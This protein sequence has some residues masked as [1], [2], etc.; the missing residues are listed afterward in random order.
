MI[1][2]QPQI[3]LLTNSLRN[4]F[5]NYLKE[6]L[7]QCQSFSLSVAFISDSGL[8]LIIDELKRLEKKGIKGRLLTTNYEYKTTPKALEMLAELSNIEVKVFDALNSSRKFH[9]KGYI[10]EMND[11]FEIVVGSSNLTQYALKSNHEWNLKYASKTD[12]DLNNNL[13]LEFDNLFN[14]EKSLPLTKDFILK[15]K[16]DYYNRKLTDR[17]EKTLLKFFAEYL[18]KYPDNEFINEMIDNNVIDKTTLLDDISTLSKEEIKPNEMQEMALEGLNSIRQSGGDKALVI[19]ATGTGKTYLSAFDALQIM[20]KRL[21]FV[22]HRSKILMDALRTFKTILP[23]ISMGQYTGQTKELDNDFIFASMQTVSKKDNLMKFNRDHF[24]YIIIDEA[25]RTAADSYQ[26]VINHFKPK[27][28]LGMTAIPER[29]DSKS[30]YELYDNQIGVEIRLREALAKELVVPFHY[31]GIRDATTDLS[32]IN[33][34]TEIDKL[35]EKLNIKAR[36]DLVIENIE[37]YKHSGEKT[38]ALGYCVNVKHAQYMAD[39]FNKRGY[40]SVALTGESSE[41]LREMYIHRLED[42]NDVLSYIFTVEIFNEGIDIPSVNLVLMLRPTSSAIIFT[43]QL[44]RGLRKYK[45]KEYLTVLDF[46]GNHNKNFLLPIALAGDKAYDKDDL[47]VSTANDFFDIPGDTFIRIDPI[48]KERILKQLEVI[49]FNEMGYLKESYQDKKKNLGRIPR[50]T[51]FAFDEF[52]PVRFIKKKRSYIGFVASLEKDNNTI[53]QM[54]H[55]SNFSKIIAY[56]DNQLPIKR[57]YEYAIL[58]ELMINKSL[59]LDE[60]F[61]HMKKYVNRPNN[62][63]YRHAVQNLYF[64]FSSKTDKNKYLKL[65]SLDDSTIGLSESFANV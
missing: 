26:R 46:I 12:S 38:K 2:R 64:K 47:I 56:L 61:S 44:G 22:V 50:L 24:D 4:S 34:H 52:D 17:G 25:H 7:D 13:L 62:D 1:T 60:L 35:A 63:S 11:H 3:Q 65:I 8:Q 21:L 48:S 23:D 40:P 58:K 51:D 54:L 9:T 45:D 41:Q 31:F 18:K 49:N 29:T 59:T 5:Y 55:N 53:N 33:I 39:Q 57:V 6:S 28:L 36:V 27:F 20:P 42:D 10:F 32:K 43:Q 30:I 14:D 16:K 15:Y 19:A 37:K